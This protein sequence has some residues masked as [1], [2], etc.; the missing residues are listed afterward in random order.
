MNILFESGDYFVVG[1]DK[2]FDVYRMGVT[3]ATRCAQ[4]GYKGQRGLDW[5]KA[6]I[7]RR[8]ALIAEAAAS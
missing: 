5:C 1:V 7:A 4:C 2:G 8:Q 6:E 3:C